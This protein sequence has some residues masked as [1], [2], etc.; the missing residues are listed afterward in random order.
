M[1]DPAQKKT[2]EFTL[3]MNEIWDDDRDFFD[4]KLRAKYVDIQNSQNFDSS[5]RVSTNLIHCTMLEI[6]SFKCVPYFAISI[7]STGSKVVVTRRY[8]KVIA[9]LGEIGGN[10]EIIFLAFFLVYKFYRDHQYEKVKR[11]AILKKVDEKTI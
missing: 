6:Q 9:T 10:R 2:K 7:F 8:P 5:Q 4:D 11:M 1:L 3:R